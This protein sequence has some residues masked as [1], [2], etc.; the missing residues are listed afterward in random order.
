M[1]EQGAVD[2]SR[3]AE[4]HYSKEAPTAPGLFPWELLR[5]RT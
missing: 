3:I 2:M 4:L 5:C 1:K